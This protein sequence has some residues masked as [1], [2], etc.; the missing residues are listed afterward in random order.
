MKFSYS[1]FILIIFILNNINNIAGAADYT[2]ATMTGDKLGRIEDVVSEAKADFQRNCLAANSSFAM[3]GFS[4]GM[5]VVHIDSVSMNQNFTASFTSGSWVL[6]TPSCASSPLPSSCNVTLGSVVSASGVQ[7]ATTTV[8]APEDIREAYV[9]SVDITYSPGIGSVCSAANPPN[10]CPSQ[11]N[12]MVA[13]ITSEWGSL[14][15]IPAPSVNVTCS[16]LGAGA[17]ATGCTT[18]DANADFVNVP[19]PANPDRNPLA[20]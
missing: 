16:D 12:T 8:P 9:K 14:L 5:G 10:P 17:T 19:L 4:F 15:S 13:A 2:V 1:K 11:F 7:V 6:P 3:V 18:C 20:Y